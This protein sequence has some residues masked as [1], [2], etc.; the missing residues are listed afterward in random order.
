MQ[1]IGIHIRTDK[2][3]QI[4]KQTVRRIKKQTGKRKKNR[5]TQLD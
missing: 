1:T 2:Q 3:R 5:Q 4:K